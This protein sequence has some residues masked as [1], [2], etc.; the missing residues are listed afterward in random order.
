MTDHQK[1][2]RKGEGG[3]GHTTGRRELEDC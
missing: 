2:R 3:K 1:K